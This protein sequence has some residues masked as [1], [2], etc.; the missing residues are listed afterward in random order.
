MTYHPP[1]TTYTEAEEQG[2]R[3]AMLIAEAEE[4]A[5]RKALKRAELRRILE[6][7]A[8]TEKPKDLQ[9]FVP[10]KEIKDRYPTYTTTWL[11]DHGIPRV[12]V[13]GETHYSLKAVE[14]KHNAL[15]GIY[16]QK[17]LCIVSGVT[18]YHLRLLA[19][20][21][22]IKAAKTTIRATYYDRDDVIAAAAKYNY[23]T[24]RDLAKLKDQANNGD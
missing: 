1:I 4:H 17:E 12:C 20:I 10:A 2:I 9:D 14:Q 8:P 6:A 7:D 16:T 5:R 19:K 13:F 3:N 23:S 18:D 15:A 24:A 11:F 22:A 21:G